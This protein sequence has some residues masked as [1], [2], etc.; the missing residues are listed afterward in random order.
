[1]AK[2]TANQSKE[3]DKNKTWDGF[4]RFNK[5]P[6]DPDKAVPAKPKLTPEELLREKFKVL[7]NLEDLEKK[8]IKL[9]KK[10]NMES[11]LQEMQGEYE[12]IVA[13]REKAASC[14]FQGRML[15]AAI[16]GIEFR[17]FLRLLDL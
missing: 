14:K 6:M 15:M 5:V 10:Y 3:H 8:G 1:M 2:V 4:G 11:S 7:R 13:E 12:M 17:D 16:T 9:T